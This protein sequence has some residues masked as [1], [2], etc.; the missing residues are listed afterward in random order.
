MFEGLQA[1]RKELKEAKLENPDREEI[2]DGYQLRF[3]GKDY[4]K[5][6]TGLPTET[7]LVPDTEWNNQ[8][9]NKN[10]ENIFITGDNLDALKHLE[11]AYSG[12]I[13]MI[14][15]DPPYNTGKDD[16]FTYPDKFEFSDE[17]LREK[18]GLSEN[19][20]SRI[21]ALQGRSSHSAWLTFMLPRLVI[22]KRLLSDDGVIFVSIDENEQANLK[23]LCD[24]IFTENNF[25]GMFSV[26]INPKGRKN[27]KF[28]SYS[29]DYCLVY[30][31]NKNSP[32]SYFIENVPKDKDSFKKDL[33]DD[34]FYTTG[35]RVLVG[36]SSNDYVTNFKSEKHYSVYYNSSQNLLKIKKEKSINDIDTLLVKEGYKRYISARDD[37]FIENTYT[38]KEFL[39]LFNDNALIFNELT[40]YE[41]DFNTHKRIKS[42]LVN[43]KKNGIDLKT[44]TAG[45]LLREMGVHFS[46]PKNVEFIKLLVSLFDDEDMIVLDFFAGSATTAHAIMALNNMDKG[47]RKYIMVQLDEPTF[48]IKNG[49]KVAKKGRNLA[50]KSGYESIDQISRAR[51]KKAAELL[52]DTSGF[53]HYKLAKV[54]D[55]NVLDKIDTFNPDNKNLVAED[56]LKPFTGEALNTG[57]TATGIQTLLTTWLVDDGYVFT[58]PVKEEKFGGYTAYMPQDSHRLYLI[59]TGWNSEATK[60]LLNKIGKNNLIVQSIVIYNH[61][62]DFTTLTELKNNLKFVL[63]NDIKLIERF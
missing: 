61:S 17:E 33:N 57:L 38:E 25:I 19:E 51:I 14:Y 39:N 7:V 12:R 47:N 53:K 34:R 43:D 1:I 3:V 11:N 31:K 40:I 24:E 28:I 23:L 45:S 10:S 48:E 29:N 8:E 13:K 59:D 52:G 62:F 60:D 44:E 49:K 56:M 5:F 36:E 32:D 15:I 30:A 58:T 6:I 42:L 4:A 63:N 20:M 35:Q 55:K 37:E 18:L 27:S 41:K 9:Q 16:D 21:K 26:E 22:A 54:D 50:F 2:H 46:N